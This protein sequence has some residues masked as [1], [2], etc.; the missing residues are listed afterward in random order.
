MNKLYQFQN[1]TTEVSIQPD[2]DRF[3]VTVGDQSYIIAARQ[4]DPGHFLL[5]VDGRKLEVYTARNSPRHYVALN[6]ET[7]TLEKTSRTRRSQPQIDGHDD[8]TALMPGV[9]LEVAV[10]EGDHVERGQT[11][12][13]LEAMKMELRVTAPHAGDVSK[14]HCK[15]GQVV[16]R[17]QL[18]VEVEAA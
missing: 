3:R 10:A 18:L 2:G 11:L 12:L 16:E 6:G 7:W 14:V 17:G 5:E 9:V 8:L 13:L 1:S 15:T 4:L